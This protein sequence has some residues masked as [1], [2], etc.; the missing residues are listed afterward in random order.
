MAEAKRSVTLYLESWQQRMA[1]DFSGLKR[2]GRWSSL[3]IE[4]GPG[5][6]PSSYLVPPDGMRKGDWLLYL[7]DAQ[8][9]HV[10]EQFSLRTPIS[11]INITPDAMK[12]GAVVFK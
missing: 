11:S 2:A 10:K 5:G 1:K 3:V 6:C 12:S 4:F 8:M 7:T 9:A